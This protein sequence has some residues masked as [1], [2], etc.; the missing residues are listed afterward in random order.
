MFIKTC[1][2]KHLI[3]QTTSHEK[4]STTLPVFPDINSLLLTDNLPIDKV[5]YV[6]VHDK[7]L[8]IYMC[9]HYVYKVLYMNQVYRI[10][11]ITGIINEL[12]CVSLACLL[13]LELQTHTNLDKTLRRTQQ[14]STS[15]RTQQISTNKTEI[16]A[17][18]NTWYIVGHGRCDDKIAKMAPK[19]ELK[20]CLDCYF[21]ETQV[22]YRHRSTNWHQWEVSLLF[23]EYPHN[24]F[25]QK[26]IK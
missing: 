3:L 5:L 22:L 26:L 16:S 24:N 19:N 12:S 20:K 21:F 25:L 6:R 17:R 15:N 8:S 13:V 11:I 1:M 18:E 14:I 7:V 9:M 2:Y 23:T 4:P 10:L